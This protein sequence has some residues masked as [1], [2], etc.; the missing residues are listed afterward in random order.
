MIER[1]RILFVE[2]DESLLLTFSAGLEAEGYQVDAVS[3]TDEALKRLNNGAYGI[4]V[5]DIYIDQRSGIDV[6]RAAH[7]NNPACAVIVIT[8]QGTMETVM[9]ATAG[10]AF[11]YLAKPFDVS[12]L[13]E[14]VG[15]AEKHLAGRTEKSADENEIPSTEMVG[16]SAPMVEVY[17]T[18]SRAAPTDVPVLIEGESGTGKEL[19]AQLIHKNSR[20]AGQPFLPVDCGSIAP[21]LMESE[22]FGS[23]R[24]AFTGAERDRMGL[25]ESADGGTVFLDEIAEVDG[26]FQ[27][28][29]LRFIQEKEVRPL[30]SSKSR[31]LDV[32]IVAATNRDLPVM[33]EKGEFRRDLWF[34]LNV[35][36]IRLPALRERR[37]DISP[38]AQHFLDRFRE[39]YQRDVSLTRSGLKALEEQDWPGNV[40]QLEHLLERMVILSPAAELDSGC[41]YEALDMLDPRP[42]AVRSLA[43]AE[44]EQIRKV[45]NATGGNK[46]RAAQILNI[47]RKTL[48][49]KLDRMKL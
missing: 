11:D 8:G 27:L 15:R 6:L 13:A 39:R 33:V 28:K 25:L 3:S 16:F 17:K 36:R 35:V 40:R 32:R 2:D 45:L 24:G 42:K 41:V 38:L 14:T 46:T 47:E 1:P 19:V 26:S 44:E 34:R 10:G 7:E 21:S 22:L 30:G 4:V 5:T 49:R 29:L 20:R 23:V 43:D 9:Q 18:I 12:R 31:K 48:Y 37:S